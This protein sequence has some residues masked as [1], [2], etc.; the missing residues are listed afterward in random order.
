MDSETIYYT[1]AGTSLIAL[2]FV[3]FFFRRHSQETVGDVAGQVLATKKFGGGIISANNVGGIRIAFGAALLL[4][5]SDWIY[6][7]Q[8]GRGFLGSK[9]AGYLFIFMIISGI[10]SLRR[11]L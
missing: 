1:L 11:R 9:P 10:A 5:A 2:L 8:F 6:A 3:L 4:F 7:V